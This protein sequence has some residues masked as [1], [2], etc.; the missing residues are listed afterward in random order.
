MWGSP[1]L[2]L[3]R[4]CGALRFRFF[5]KSNT[6]SCKFI[7][8]SIFIFC[9]SHQSDVLMLGSYLCSDSF[10]LYLCFVAMLCMAWLLMIGKA[11]SF[12]FFFLRGD[13]LFSKGTAKLHLVRF[14]FLHFWIM[15]KD[16]YETFYFAVALIF[17]V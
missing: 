8:K 5:F 13:L 4:N 6:V 11:K 17:K 16:S 1:N 14:L 10:N 9:S 7:V 15:W 2:L 12:L 3:I